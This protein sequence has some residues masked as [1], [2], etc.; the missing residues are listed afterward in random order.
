MSNNENDGF[1]DQDNKSDD[2]KSDDIKSDDIK[3][4]DIK[5]EGLNEN[6]W[7]SKL[8]RY[9]VKI[10]E[11]SAGWAWMQNET[12]RKYKRIDK[13]MGYILGIFS[14]LTGTTS[15]LAEFV[16]DNISILRIV[17]G[18]IFTFV[19]VLSVMRENMRNSEQ[20]EVRAT[21]A[22][23]FKEIYYD[24]QQQMMIPRSY[25]KSASDY[26]EWITSKFNDLKEDSPTLSNNIV[27]KYV[28]IFE[29]TKI[30]MPDIVG[31][32]D[33]IR[34]NCSHHENK[35]DTPDKEIKLSTLV[36]ICHPDVESE[37]E[38]EGSVVVN[39]SDTADQRYEL[40]RFFASTINSKKV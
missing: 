22:N 29:K 37:S 39:I 27:Q 3:S 8:E 7:N 12:A 30:S 13:Y 28:S 33:R 10:G 18:I 35:K 32:I 2:T 24:I 11:K 19:G 26:V 20:M 31:K 17:F 9:S 14:A 16:E 4:N 25:R 23:K 34:V 38:S 15:L 21:K 36:N 40:D 5:S 1:K 6:L